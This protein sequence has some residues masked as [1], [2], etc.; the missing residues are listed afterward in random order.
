LLVS[1]C[2]AMGLPSMDTFGNTDVGKGPLPGFL[3]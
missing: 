2:N 3:K 1:I